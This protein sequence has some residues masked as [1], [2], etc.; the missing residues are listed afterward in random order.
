MHTEM[1]Y[2]SDGGIKKWS[3]GV[4]E[5]WK[6]GRGNG[7]METCSQCPNTA[8]PKYSNTPIPQYSITPVLHLPSNRGEPI[9]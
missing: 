5:W 9:D 3:T 8:T 1:E 6:K 2:W 7:V 4:M